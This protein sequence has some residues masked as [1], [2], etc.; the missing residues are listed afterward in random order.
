MVGLMVI[1]VQF[2]SFVKWVEIKHIWNQHTVILRK[3]LY[4][5][6]KSEWKACFSE[7]PDHE[8]SH[9]I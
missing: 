6:P 2:V 8:N 7:I 9:H 1:L 4:L 5:I 3:W